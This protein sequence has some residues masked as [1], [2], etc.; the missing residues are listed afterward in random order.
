[1]T[2]MGTTTTGTLGEPPRGP[3]GR[4]QR[5]VSLR[6]H[7]A[8]RA[9]QLAPPPGQ[10]AVRRGRGT[11]RARLRRARRAHGSDGTRRRRGDRSHPP[12][13]GAARGHRLACGASARRLAPRGRRA[14]FAIGSAMAVP[15]QIVAGLSHQRYLA[16]VLP[17][18]V[19]VVLLAVPTTRRRVREAR[20][21]A[22]P[23]WFAPAVAV[24]SLAVH[25]AVPRLRHRQ[26]DQLHGDH[27]PAHRHVSAPGARRPA[28]DPR[29]GVMAHRRGRGPRLPLVHPCLARPGDGQLGSGAQRS[30]DADHAG[31]HAD[32]R[33]A[34]GRDHRAAA[35]RQGVGRRAGS[36]SSP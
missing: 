7:G 29:P 19:T 31:P 6:G 4:Q 32:G 1:M 27:C 30:A 8:T 34:G 17:R 23:W 36:G 15:V 2:G 18:L 9:Q 11:R 26:P 20:W 35:E 13:P 33:R 28:A 3:I 22:V 25:P 21:G 14:G 5:A 12:D 24:T 10:P 16:I